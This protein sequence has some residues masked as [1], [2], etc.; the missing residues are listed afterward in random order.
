MIVV[1][2]LMAGSCRLGLA[3]VVAGM[4]LVQVLGIAA[5][6]KMRA[7]AHAGSSDD[8]AAVV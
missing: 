4:I 7:L 2:C 8:E 5:E 1:A 6:R 3:G